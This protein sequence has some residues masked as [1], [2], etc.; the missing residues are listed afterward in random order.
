LEESQGVEIAAPATRNAA[1]Q[2]L[3]VIEAALCLTML[4]LGQQDAKEAELRSSEKWTRFYADA[5][6]QYKVTRGDG[7]EPVEFQDRAVFDWASINDFNGAVFA[8]TENGRPTLLA[9][10]FSLP[11][12]GS[13]QRLVVHEFASF[14]EADTVVVGP[15]GEKWTPK[16]AKLQPLPGV[17]RP[18]TRPNLLAAVRRL[19]KE[20]T[21]HLN[22]RGERWDL[23]LLPSPLVEYQDPADD[24][25][26]GGLFAFVGYSTD[27]EILLSLEAR[28]LKDGPAWCFQAVR[29]SDKSLY[30]KFKDK[31]V[32]ESL[33]TGHGVEAGDTDDPQYRVLHSAR[34]SPEV[35]EKLSAP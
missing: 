23:R 25:L 31:P 15:S 32:W 34:L 18:P 4:V 5:A 17:S 19:A 14:A 26:G 11:V 21:A 1:D 13:P 27:P 35:I 20:F 33:R 16:G 9:S 24:I 29:F 30:L 10:I 6:R 8:W 2:E 3:T 22:R 7:N 28:E 12:T